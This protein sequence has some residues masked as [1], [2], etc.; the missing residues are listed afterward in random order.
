MA[1]F[2]LCYTFA[3]NVKEKKP[4][5]TTVISGLQALIRSDCWWGSRTR[6]PDKRAPADLRAVTLAT[7]PPESNLYETEALI[8]L[9][10]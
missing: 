9:S 4:S 7:V 10:E 3:E 1:V 2:A 8:Q 5:N 6:S